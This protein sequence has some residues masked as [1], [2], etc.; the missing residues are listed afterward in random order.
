ML[1]SISFANDI[2]YRPNMAR[3]IV[4]RKVV[5]EIVA[6]NGYDRQGAPNVPT[7]L[8][9]RAL[10]ALHA[11]HALLYLLICVFFFLIAL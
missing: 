2:F 8:I 9:S 5:C 1:I 4:E 11:L 3:V 7:C 10:H 6:T